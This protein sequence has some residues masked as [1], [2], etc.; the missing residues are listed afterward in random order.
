MQKSTWIPN[1]KKPL[2]TN[3]RRC[4]GDYWEHEVEEEIEKK[5][6]AGWTL[7]GNRARRGKR[8]L[9]FTKQI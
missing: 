2:K 7:F 5:T 6:K 1:F 9:I 4:E 8:R 3:T